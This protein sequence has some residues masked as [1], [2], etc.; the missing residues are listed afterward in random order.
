VLPTA[1]DGA[2]HVCP[3][4]AVPNIV[5]ACNASH[6]VT[7]L[8]DEVLVET[9][10]PI[11]QG[12]HVRL[13]IHDITEPLEGCVAPAEEHI[14][15]LIDFAL[16]WGGRGPVVVHCWA[17]ISRSTAAAYTA[18]CAIN[19]DAPEELIAARLRQ[20]S[21]TAYPNRL[22]IRLADEALGRRGRMVRAIEA[23]GRGIIAGEALPF[24]LPAD[25]T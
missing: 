24:S 16:A 5:A 23:I 4:S 7:C 8:Q 18:L 25:H 1:R 3:L 6:L 12:N 9:P 19:P 20:A 14:A 11:P 2:I 15:E 17:G 10:R 21:A 13:R 22:M